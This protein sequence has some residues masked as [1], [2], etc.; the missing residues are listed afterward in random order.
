MHRP[1]DIVV[2]DADCGA[3]ETGFESRKRHGCAYKCTVSSQK[4]GTPNSLQTASPLVRIVEEEEMWEVPDNP[5]CVLSQ[6]WGGNE[7]NLPPAWC[8]KLRLTTGDR[9]R[10]PSTQTAD[11]IPRSS[12]PLF[13]E[14][15]QQQTLHLQREEKCTFPYASVRTLAMAL[16]HRSGQLDDRRGLGL[17][18]GSLHQCL[19]GG[20]ERTAR[21]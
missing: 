17:R 10:P 14:E 16:G 9:E 15:Q 19:S 8:S 2:S 7:Q 13:L 20:V 5:Q 11:D 3:V 12:P 4:R 1:Y 18:R 6:N 21:K